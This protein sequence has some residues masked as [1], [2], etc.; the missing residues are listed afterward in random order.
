MVKLNSMHNTQQLFNQSVVMS[1]P[2]Q[3]D[4]KTMGMTARIGDQRQRLRNQVVQK[5]RL[6]TLE[7]ETT[8]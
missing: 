1:G 2:L 3:A 5:H 6:M 7:H 4:A 8:F